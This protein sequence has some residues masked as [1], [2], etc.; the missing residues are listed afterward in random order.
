MTSPESEPLTIRAPRHA[1]EPHP[2]MEQL[3]LRDVD[4]ET[5]ARW[6]H[7]IAR[8]GN[9][10]AAFL[11][12]RDIDPTAPDVLER[13]ERFHQG[14]YPDLRTC[15]NLLIDSMGWQDAFESFLRQH[16][17]MQGMLDWNHAEIEAAVS[18]IYEVVCFGGQVHLFDR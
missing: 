5:L 3:S 2:A 7:G 13:F 1:A 16:P 8:H 6:E 12:L 11:R 10:F 9:A 15:A 18:E 14:T 17:D 4:Q